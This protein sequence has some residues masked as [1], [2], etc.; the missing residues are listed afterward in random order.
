MCE[1]LKKLISK[2]NYFSVLSDGSTNSAATE[3]ETIYVLF[4]CEGTPVL[5]Y[6]SI[7]NVKNADAPGFKSTLEVAFSHFSI[8]HYYDKL[9]GLNLDGVSINMA[10]HNCLNVLVQDEAPWVE[11]V[12]CFNHQLELAIKDVFIESTFYSNISEMLSKLY[13]LYQKSP[14][15]LTHLKEL[16]EAFEKS[17]PKPTNADGTRWIDFKFRAMEK[18]LENYSP[19]TTHL[20]QLAHTNSQLKKHEEIKGFVNKWRDTGYLMHI[21]IFI[22]ILSPMR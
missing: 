13:W 6:L 1:E 2:A 21:A 12:H 11:V 10:K 14:K 22:D 16:S 7:E 20:E 19:Y 5:K 3:Q 4:I 15:R 9:V 18:V 17:I 8:T